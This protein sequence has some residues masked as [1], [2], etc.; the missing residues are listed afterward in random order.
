MQ[1]VRGYDREALANIFESNMVAEPVVTES[2]G[3]I[4]P[5]DFDPVE[6]DRLVRIEIANAVAGVRSE[7]FDAVSALNTKINLLSDNVSVNDGYVKQTVEDHS[8]FISGEFAGVASDLIALSN[9]V[10]AHT[11]KLASLTA[12]GS[13][14]TAGSAPTQPPG[15]QFVNS[16][17]E[18]TKNV[19][20]H[21]CVQNLEK[22][23]SVA[24]D[25]HIWQLRFKNCMT[26]VNPLYKRII[27]SCESL[28]QTVTT[29]ETWWWQVYQNIAT[30]L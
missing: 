17:T 9:V 18:R 12:T 6:S 20:D 13:Q 5:V 29:Y 28:N 2:L 4:M 11:T 22:L 16:S 14:P 15:I 24:A 21:K 27:D 19:M 10:D 8:K 3:D 25:F 23:T 1:R 30:T 7:L 26:Q